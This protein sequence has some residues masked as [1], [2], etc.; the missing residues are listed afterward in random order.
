MTDLSE[1]KGWLEMDRWTQAEFLPDFNVILP[2]LIAIAE[3]AQ[4][5][6]ETWGDNPKDIAGDSPQEAGLRQAV[7]GRDA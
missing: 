4:E 5:L 6:V 1:L 2:S 3:A 7:S